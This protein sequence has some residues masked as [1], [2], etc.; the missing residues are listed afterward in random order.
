MNCI[1]EQLKKCIIISCQSEGNDP[2]NADPEYMALFAKA[3]EMGGA[4]GIRTQGIEKLKAIGYI[5][6]STIYTKYES[7]IDN[8]KKAAR[9]NESPFII[10]HE[11]IYEL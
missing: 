9:C 2:F 3:A 8:T 5:N 4:K 7:K 6:T 1:I 10:I 11:N